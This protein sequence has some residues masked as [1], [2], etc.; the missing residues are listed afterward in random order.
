[1][2]NYLRI[3]LLKEYFSSAE[4]I[5]KIEYYKK[6][7]I[8]LN[9]HTGKPVCK[10]WH[11]ILDVESLWLFLYWGI[12][13]TRGDGCEGERLRNIPQAHIFFRK[14]ISKC[15]TFRADLFWRK[16]KQNK[17][18]ATK[19]FGATAVSQILK[20]SLRAVTFRTASK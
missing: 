7:N 5:Q 18:R 8:K 19:P 9:F 3:T 14:L 12:L 1:M 6:S 2:W 20:R 13:I 15:K 11:K 17:N 4:S 10:L 16:V